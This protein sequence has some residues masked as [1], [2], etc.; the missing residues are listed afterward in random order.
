MEEGRAG[1]LGSTGSKM[2]PSLLASMAST[3]RLIDQASAAEAMPYVTRFKTWPDK[4]RT[5][6]GTEEWWHRGRGCIPMEGRDAKG[7]QAN[8]K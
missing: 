8:P 4:A 3:R 1:G 2:I 6:L 5:V 7:K